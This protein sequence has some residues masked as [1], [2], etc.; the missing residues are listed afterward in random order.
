MILNWIINDS[1][2]KYSSSKSAAPSLS[3]SPISSLPPLPSAAQRQLPASASSTPTAQSRHQH[4]AR[5]KSSSA[6]AAAIVNPRLSQIRFGE[7]LPPSPSLTIRASVTF[8]LPPPPTLFIPSLYSRSVFIVSCSFS[9]RAPFELFSLTIPRSYTLDTPPG[10][11]YGTLLYRFSHPTHYSCYDH[12]P[13]SRR[14]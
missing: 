10:S 12:T 6:A 7:I 3:P 5:A 4:H 13:F 11:D 1:S 2:R 8:I 14:I 9:S